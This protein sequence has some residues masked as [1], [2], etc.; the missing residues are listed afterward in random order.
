MKKI[1]QI[2]AIFA[3]AALASPAA[4]LQSQHLAVLRA[5]DVLRTFLIS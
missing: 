5:G 3:L 2:A 4:S 1:I